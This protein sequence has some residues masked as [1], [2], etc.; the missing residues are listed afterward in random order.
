MEFLLFVLNGSDGEFDWKM[1]IV[2]WYAQIR[3]WY[4]NLYA[5]QVLSVQKICV[6]AQTMNRLTK[7]ICR[8]DYDSESTFRKKRPKLSE[9]DKKF[10]EKECTQRG[11]WTRNLWIKSPTLYRLS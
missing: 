7:F 2:F 5:I 6:S 4:Y 9:N 8:R 10:V 3:S 1:T 11:A